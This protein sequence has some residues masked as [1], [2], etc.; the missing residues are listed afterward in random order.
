MQ[1]VR[2]VESV[3]AIQANANAFLDMKVKAAR[4]QLARMRALVT[5]S[6]LTLKTWGT[7]QHT[8]SSTREAITLAE[9]FFLK[10]QSPWTTTVGT[11]TKLV[12]AFVTLSTEMWTAQRECVLMERTSWISETT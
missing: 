7:N 5:G 3:T 12:D 8:S 2:P 6:A 10:V 4:G 11:N 9:T 1:S